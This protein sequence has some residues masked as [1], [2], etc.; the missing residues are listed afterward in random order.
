MSDFRGFGKTGGAASFPKSH[1]RGVKQPVQLPWDKPCNR[2]QRKRWT[3]AISTLQG[4][5]QDALNLPCKQD[6]IIYRQI[7]GRVYRLLC[8]MMSLGR[9]V[10]SLVT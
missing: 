5:H 3:T 9:L 7:V 4:L 1:L 2:V 8:V 6:A 10:D